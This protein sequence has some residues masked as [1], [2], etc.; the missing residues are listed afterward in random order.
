MRAR[1]TGGEPRRL[2]LTPPGEAHP[3]RLTCTVSSRGWRREGRCRSSHRPSPPP[4]GRSTPEATRLGA[5]PQR[6]AQTLPISALPRGFP[7]TG[8]LHTRVKLPRCAAAPEN[9]TP[10][11]NSAQ[12][13]PRCPEVFYLERKLQVP[14][15][16]IVVCCLPTWLLL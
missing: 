7:F 2:K 3:S 1:V 11:L 8:C 16:P 10:P 15:S 4:D 5:L 12:R 14:L 13:G 9:S 6:S